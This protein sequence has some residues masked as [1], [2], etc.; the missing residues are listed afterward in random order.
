[1]IPFGMWD[2]R[3]GAW[4]PNY[5]LTMTKDEQ[6][7]H[8]VKWGYLPGGG[9]EMKVTATANKVVEF[10]VQDVFGRKVEIQYRV[11]DTDTGEIVYRGDEVLTKE[12]TLRVKVNTSVEA[13]R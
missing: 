9:D 13:E 1:M 5:R 6:Y 7:A 11:K 8:N 12:D 10:Y 3:T 4:T 2:I